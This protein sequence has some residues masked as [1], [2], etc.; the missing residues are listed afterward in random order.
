MIEAVDA[1]P[2]AKTH[3]SATEPDDRI[4]G[5]PMGTH[6]ASQSDKAALSGSLSSARKAVEF[7]KSESPRQYTALRKKAETHRSRVVSPE[8]RRERT[9]GTDKEMKL[10]PTTANTTG[11]QNMRVKVA[12]T[13]RVG[14]SLNDSCRRDSWI[15]LGTRPKLGCDG[16][17]IKPVREVART[18]ASVKLFG[19]G[20]PRAKRTDATGTCAIAADLRDSLARWAPRSRYLHV[21]RPLP[22]CP[23]F[24]WPLTP[25]PLWP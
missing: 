1:V 21:L 11:P 19:D 22:I 10:Q 16:R 6:C 14:F 8:K 23:Q 2:T 3:V 7:E 18:A 4:L 24:S 9:N 13:Q 25:H 5:P 15:S 12:G 20:R 17:E